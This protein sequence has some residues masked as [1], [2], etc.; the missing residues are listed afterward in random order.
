V[1][2]EGVSGYVVPRAD[3][4]AAA[5]ALAQRVVELLGNPELCVRLGEA[6]A[7]RVMADFVPQAAARQYERAY[8]RAMAVIR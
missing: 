2:E 8:R 7:S 4:E 3:R 6:G 5:G 1:V